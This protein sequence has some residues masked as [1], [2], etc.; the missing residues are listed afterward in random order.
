[1]KPTIVLLTDFGVK[2]EYV[3]VMKGVILSSC[4]Q[5]SI[6]DLSHEVRA[7]NIL[8]A[9]V[10]LR[11]AYRFFPQRSLFVCVVDPSV[12]TDRKI[13]YLKTQNYSFLAPDNGLLGL[14]V[15][16]EKKLK[17]LKVSMSPSKNDKIS[18]TFHGRDVFAPIAAYLAN[19]GEDK[20]LGNSLSRICS[21]KYPATK[22]IK[23]KVFGEIIYFD[24]FG[25]A[26]SNI[27]KRDI[28][29]TKFKRVI[30]KKRT[31]P[32]CKNYSESKRLLALFNSN[33]LLEI[34]Q[35]NGS[36]QA[37]ARL[38]IGEKVVLSN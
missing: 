24:H 3:G 28:N 14:V 31:V 15:Q 10:I 22:T 30:I 13:I 32:I 34:S 11:N 21:L 37:Q 12:G 35:P 8:Q 36:A 25:N 1:M 17:L 20:T 33:D 2:D 26:I 23:G 38:K 18:N 5:A 16:Q 29:G 9:A 19:G 4:P 7:Q 27:C 6:I